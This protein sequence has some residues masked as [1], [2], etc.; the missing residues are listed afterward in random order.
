MK[1]VTSVMLLG[2]S[3]FSKVS[4]AHVLIIYLNVFFCRRTFH[5]FALS[6]FGKNVV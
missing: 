4:W 2:S 3:K 6:L 5:F 1:P